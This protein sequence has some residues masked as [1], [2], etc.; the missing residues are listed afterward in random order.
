MM[1]DLCK[2]IDQPEVEGLPRKWLDEIN[3]RKIPYRG[4][5]IKDVSKKKAA[6]ELTA[7]LA[8]YNK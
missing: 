4:P 6:D 8:K 7:I 3:Q 2:H 1:S 5:S